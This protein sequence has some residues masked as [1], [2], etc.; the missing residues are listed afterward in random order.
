M[1]DPCIVKHW[2]ILP[3]VPGEEV[4]INLLFMIIATV[5]IKSNHGYIFLI[6]ST[7]FFLASKV[8]TE[9]PAGVQNEPGFD[10]E[11]EM[12]SDAVNAVNNIGLRSSSTK[13]NA[14]RQKTSLQLFLKKLS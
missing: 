1:S 11:N 13:K 5:N 7:S 4:E 2:K 10:S 14:V 3:R 6:Q 9:T 12:D 8:N